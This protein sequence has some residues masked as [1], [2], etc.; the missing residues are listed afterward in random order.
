MHGRY[1]PLLQLKVSFLQNILLRK[2]M[3]AG[4]LRNGQELIDIEDTYNVT[5]VQLQDMCNGYIGRRRKRFD[6]VLRY[7][8][9][10]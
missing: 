1:S 4:G 9:L 3:L 6:F 7:L 5:L 10:R 8:R 2:K